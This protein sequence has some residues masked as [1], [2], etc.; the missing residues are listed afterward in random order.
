[1]IGVVEG[2]NVEVKYPDKVCSVN[3]AHY[4]I[5]AVCL[6]G[7]FR[8]YHCHVVK[9]QPVYWSDAVKMSDLIRKHGIDYAYNASLRSRKKTR[10]I[11]E[12]LS[13]V[14]GLIIP[15]EVIQE[16][17][18]ENVESGDIS[19]WNSLEAS[20]NM[21]IMKDKKAGKKKMKKYLSH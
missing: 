16:L 18:K 2:D 12:A 14:T 4:Y 17:R 1:M 8:C 20:E 3:G 5:E 13:T 6:S 15:E 11:I 7:I 21:K 19:P 9:W 10:L